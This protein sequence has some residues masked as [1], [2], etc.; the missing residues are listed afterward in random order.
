MLTLVIHTFNMV[1][2]YIFPFLKIKRLKR[3]IK[4]V[5]SVEKKMLLNLLFILL[6]AEYKLLTSFQHAV[7]L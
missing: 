5:D 6:V 1:Y 2:L 7:L 4:S 3:T